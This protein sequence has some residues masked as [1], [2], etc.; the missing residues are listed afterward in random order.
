MTIVRLGNETNHISRFM[1]VYLWPA[2]DGGNFGAAKFEKVANF[3]KVKKSRILEKWGFQ[4]TGIL[5]E[6]EQYETGGMNCQRA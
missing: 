4:K 1:K 6:L 5:A 3:F 2:D